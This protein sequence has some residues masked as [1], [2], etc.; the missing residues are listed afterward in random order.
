MFERLIVKERERER[1]RERENAIL[2]CSD[3]YSIYFFAVIYIL[4]DVEQL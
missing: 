3:F 4:T 2:L 1:E